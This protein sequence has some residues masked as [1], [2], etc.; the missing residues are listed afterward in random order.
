MVTRKRSEPS[1][2]LILGVHNEMKPQRPSKLKK[3]RVYSTKKTIVNVTDDNI[4]CVSKQTKSPTQSPV[5]L[6]LSSTEVTKKKYSNRYHPPSD[7]PDPISV[8]AW[9]R[10]ARKI[11]NPGSTRQSRNKARNLITDLESKVEDL[12]EKYHLAM[13]KIRTKKSHPEG[14]L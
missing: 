7:L 8:S 9:R 12:K 4:L 11:R 1:T 10:A 2:M 5:K 14:W 3:Q 6:L 13:E